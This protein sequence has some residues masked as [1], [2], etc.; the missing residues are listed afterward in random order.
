MDLKTLLTPWNWFKKEEEAQAVPIQRMAKT[1]EHSLSRLHSDIDKL[2]ENFFHGFPLSPF[3]EEGKTTSGGFILPQVDIG[4][5]EDAY[6]IKVEAPGVEEKDIELT[7][8]DGTLIVRGEKRY[9]KEDE[10]K[11]FH[12][13]ERS[14]GSFQRMLSL[15]PDADDS[16]VEAKFK[17]GLLTISIGKNPESPSATRKIPIS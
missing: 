3:R 9:E 8:S 5:S 6:T 16:K 17:N 4:E 12:R 10:E 14:Y 7:V 13:I 15:P 1:P 2:F 11:H